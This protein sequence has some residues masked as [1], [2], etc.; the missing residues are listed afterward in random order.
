MYRNYLKC[1]DC[2]FKCNHN[3]NCNICC[4]GVRCNDCFDCCCKI[5]RCRGCFD[6]CDC[7]CNCD[8]DACL[9]FVFCF[10]YPVIIILFFIGLYKLIV[11]CGKHWARIFSVISLI[12][13]DFIIFVISFYGGKDYGLDTYLI[14][15]ISLAIFCMICNLLGM[16]LPNCKTCKT[17]RYFDPYI[18]P[19]NIQKK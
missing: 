14:I 5:F 17:F 6:C 18:Q 9:I 7:R 11:Y 13:C 10:I 15:N 12:L 3:C 1:P 19:N 16:T 8:R 2:N 4:E